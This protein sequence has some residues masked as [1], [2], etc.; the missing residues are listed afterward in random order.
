MTLLAKNLKTTRK[1]LCLTQSALARLLDIGFR[2]Y[3]RYET[4][5]RDTPLPVLVKIA[6]LGKVSLDR[7]LTTTLTLENLDIADSE[8]TPHKA[9]KL[10]II[11]GG[12]KEGKAMFIGLKHYHLI[13]INKTEKALL[14]AYRN[15]NNLKKKNA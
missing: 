9:G 11:G 8:A 3:V 6:K 13:T 1:K 12:L 2:T 4:A 10:E 15:F 7:L 5:K 14:L